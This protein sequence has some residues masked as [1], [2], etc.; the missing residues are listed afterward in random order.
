MLSNGDELE[1]KRM[2]ETL[3]LYDD[4]CDVSAQLCFFCDF[5]LLNIQKYTEHCKDV[6][7]VGEPGV[8]AF[9]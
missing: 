8:V 5:M 9:V 4:D 7:G 1:L 2:Y 3:N 6:S